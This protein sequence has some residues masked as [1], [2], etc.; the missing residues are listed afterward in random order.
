[1]VV[2][3][4]KSAI[5]SINPLGFHQH[6]TELHKIKCLLQV[7]LTENN[8]GF[9]VSCHDP[10]R[11]NEK[12]KKSKARCLEA[13][14]GASLSSSTWTMNMDDGDYNKRQDE[15]NNRAYVPDIG[16]NSSASMFE[17]PKITRSDRVPLIVLYAG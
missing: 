14:H 10:C 5:Y 8:L 9:H 13:S 7:I 1:M 16:K 4:R 15:L 3:F 6:Y 12:V 17:N 11:I 2:D